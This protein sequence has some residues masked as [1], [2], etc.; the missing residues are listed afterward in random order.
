MPEPER[1]LGVHPRPAVGAARLGVDTFDVFEQ[2][3]VLLRRAADF[4]PGTPFVVAL[5]AHAKDPAGHRDVESVVGEFTDQREDYFG[6]TFSRA[7]YAAARLRISFSTSSRRVFLRSSAS[8]RFS[9]LVNRDEFERPSSASAWASQ[10]RRQ[11]SEI[12]NSFAIA[13][14]GLTRRT[15][16]VHSA[17]PELRRVRSGHE[18]HPSWRTGSASGE[19]S[20]ARGQA[21]GQFRERGPTLPVTHIVRARIAVRARSRRAAVPGGRRS[22]G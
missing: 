2:Q 22:V 6:R 21:Q 1:E 4:T 8:S 18:R 19:V 7:K 13:A 9:S 10:F 17:L 20:G 3:L 12:D 14:I 5:A 15:S 16:K 11:D